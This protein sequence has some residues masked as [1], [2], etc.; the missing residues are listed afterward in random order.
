MTPKEAPVTELIGHMK[1][2]GWHED[3]G[4]IVHDGLGL[5]FSNWTAAI[6]AC[7]EVASE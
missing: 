4:D 3:E 1:A 6:K 5:T 2:M 7:I